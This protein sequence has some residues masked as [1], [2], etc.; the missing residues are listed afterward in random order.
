MRLAVV[1]GGLQGLEAVYLA[2]KAE[3]EVRLLDRREEMP[4]RGLAHD[5]VRC[6]ATD[7]DGLERALQGVDLVLPALEDAPALE[8]LTRWAALSGTPLAFDLSA[9]AV[10]SSK[11][12]SNQLFQRLGLAMPREGPSCG[13]PLLAKPD[14][15]S[16]SRGVQVFRDEAVW[17]RWREGLGDPEAWV[18]QEYLRG[19][20]YSIE[21]LGQP[22][23]YR[24]LQ[25]TELE[26]D[27]IHDC[28]RVRAPA[29]LDGG[30]VTEFGRMAGRLAEALKLRGLM[31]LEVILHEGRLKLLEIDARLPSQTPIAV[32][33]STGC[34]MVLALGTLF[35]CGG[36]PNALPAPG[37]AVVLEHL[38]ASG[39]RL[40][41]A[42][43]HV[44]CRRGPLRVVP[45]FYGTDEAVTDL[46]PGRTD[47]VATLLVTGSGRAEAWQRRC[48]AVE[49]IRRAHGLTDYA[50]PEPPP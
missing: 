36:E 43:E 19:P 26:M 29:V 20:S 48:Q 38:H 30:L 50:D 8:S 37:R 46:E 4:A 40:E 21:V 7:L 10:S 22:D 41:V 42:G 33:W 3:W 25:V 17:Q 28:K 14:A 34:N 39:S 6:D 47:W 2:G 12:L 13:L 1:G 49:A 16:G 44:L 15:L 35:L 32:F 45:G 11:R 18:V 24:P 23:G 27:A 31:D 5:F 9:Y